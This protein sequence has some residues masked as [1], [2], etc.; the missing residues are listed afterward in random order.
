MR[1]EMYTLENRST[2][3][4]RDLHVLHEWK[5]TYA[6]EIRP[7]RINKNWHT[8]RENYLYVQKR[9]V[10]VEN[11]YTLAH[12]ALKAPWNPAGVEP[13]YYKP[14]D[15]DPGSLKW[16]KIKVTRFVRDDGTNSNK[17]GSRGRKPASR[18]LLVR[19]ACRGLRVR[20][21]RR[22]LKE[23]DESR[24]HSL[25]YTT[26][27]VWFERRTHM[28][29]ETNTHDERPTNMKKEQY[30]ERKWSYTY[31]KRPTRTNKDKHVWKW[32][33]HMSKETN[34]QKKGTTY[35]SKETYNKE[36]QTI[37]NTYPLAHIPVT[38]VVCNLTPTPSPS[39]AAIW[40]KNS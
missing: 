20:Q 13:I 24:R 36:T 32:A 8:W 1:W 37:Q 15:I 39:P 38:A 23:R 17:R 21:V 34:T 6:H 3:T 2:Y 9:H 25:H 26:H 19:Y 5:E 7:T 22:T 14:A 35:M 33:T 18:K 11:I 10:N 40:K 27:T 31:N 4:K 16:V 28:T 30:N 29:K 12:T